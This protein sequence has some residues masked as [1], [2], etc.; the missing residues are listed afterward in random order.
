MNHESGIWNHGLRKNHNSLFIIH[1][2]R[3]SAGFTLLE[4]LVSISIFVIITTAVVINYRSGEQSA[5][6]RLG[7][8]NLA[9]TLRL[10]QTMAQ[11]GK[12]V[13]LCDT[14]DADGTPDQ[15]AN[16]VC[17]VG[18]GVNCD[19]ACTQRVPTGGYGMSIVNGAVLLFADGNNN[20]VFD[21]GEELANVKTDFP[22]NIVI[23]VITET[24]DAQLAIVFLPPDAEILVNGAQAASNV[25][26]TAQHEKSGDNRTIVVRPASGRIDVK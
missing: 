25:Y 26:I 17:T 21:T 24:E 13:E 6:L 4:L 5:Q 2:S 23:G 16:Q 20:H 3:K 8:E 15:Y 9:S 14:Q 19:S 7:A 1:N 10:L 11:S 18:S 12:T 22:Q